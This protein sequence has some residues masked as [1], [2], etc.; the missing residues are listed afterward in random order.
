MPLANPP[1]S[2][3]GQW[4][5]G[6]R[7]YNC[8]KP[9]TCPRVVVDEDESLDVDSLTNLTRSVTLL[10]KRYDQ[11]VNAA[12]CPTPTEVGSEPAA[13]TAAASELAGIEDAVT[14]LSAGT[15]PLRFFKFFQR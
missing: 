2:L 4:T 12:A 6:R 11:S 9:A 8:P 14:F 15:S 13:A 5:Q 3:Q 10:Q 1:T 7:K